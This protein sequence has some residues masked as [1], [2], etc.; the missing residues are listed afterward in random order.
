MQ[1]EKEL[2][3]LDDEDAELN[4]KAL[5]SREIDDRRQDAPR[6]ALIH[7]IDEKLKQYGQ[8]RSTS[9]APKFALTYSR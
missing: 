2:V 7:D 1:L 6:K 8:S 4:P 9:H 5:I 3:D